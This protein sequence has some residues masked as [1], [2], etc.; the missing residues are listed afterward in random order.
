MRK[1]RKK[2]ISRLHLGELT[3]TTDGGARRGGGGSADNKS[4][5]VTTPD[6]WWQNG[7]YSDEEKGEK[8]NKM[9][10]V[11]SRSQHSPFGVK[12]SWVTKCVHHSGVCAGWGK[13]GRGENVRDGPGTTSNGLLAGLALP[14]SDSSTLD[15]VLSAEGAGVAGVLRDFHLLDLLTERGTVSVEVSLASVSAVGRSLDPS[16]AVSITR[17]VGDS[18]RIAEFSSVCEHFVKSS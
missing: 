10:E 1:K 12:V 14:D 2:Q 16:V 4:P 9:S 13:E 11:D 3:E 17:D 8:R 7:G 18:S 6:L 15:G 5:S